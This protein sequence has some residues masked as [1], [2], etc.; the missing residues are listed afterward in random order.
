VIDNA[1]IVTHALEAAEKSFAQNGPNP[2]V[3]DLM[4]QTIK[5]MFALSVLLHS[6]S[7]VY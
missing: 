1:Y 2:N 3:I 6:L 5:K 4:A 7:S